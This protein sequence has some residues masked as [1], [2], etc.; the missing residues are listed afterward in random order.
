MSML[1]E[2]V[3]AQKLEE[4]TRRAEAAEA[5]LADREAYLEQFRE[6]SRNVMNVLAERNKPCMWTQGDDNWFATE[7]G[8]AFEYKWGAFCPDCGHP[9]EVTP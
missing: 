9:V 2:I 4:M 6:L 3:L 5:A 7:C 8:S 1:A